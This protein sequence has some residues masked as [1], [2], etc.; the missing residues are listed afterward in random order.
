MAG[1]G[2][3]D[4]QAFIANSKAGK[5]S[6]R[7]RKFINDLKMTPQEKARGL[8]SELTPNSLAELD[9][10][11]ANQKNKK[12]RKILTD[13]RDYLHNVLD[14]LANGPNA[15]SSG[16][17]SKSSK[18]NESSKSDNSK[19]DTPSIMDQINDFLSSLWSNK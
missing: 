7:D 1:Y 16:Q 19:V 2:Q 12:S 9:Y 13:H 10:E 15:V 17:S 8:A 4:I 11:I 3:K 5:L 6:T 18:S 14:D